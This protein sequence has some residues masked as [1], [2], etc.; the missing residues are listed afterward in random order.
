MKYRVFREKELQEC[1]V[2]HFF[3]NWQPWDTHDP[4]GRQVVVSQVATISNNLNNVCCDL[5][6]SR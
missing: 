2:L 6:G 5:K 1:G 3:R 4:D